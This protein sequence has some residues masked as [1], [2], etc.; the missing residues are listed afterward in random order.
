MAMKIIYFVRHGE[1]VLNAQNIRQ[2]PDGP[3]TEKGRT[4]A[5]ETAKRFPKHGGRP[6]VIIAS[7]YQRTRETAEIIAKELHMK[8]HYSELLVE[9]KNPSEII[10]HWGEEVFV[11]KIIDQ[12]D[13]SFHTDNLRISDEEN[14]VDLKARAKKLLRFIKWRSEKRIMLVTHGI[15]LKMVVSY[16]LHGDSLTA[17]EYN[18]LSSFN[19]I[20]N[21]SMAVCSYTTHWFKK[22]DW[23][24]LVWNDLS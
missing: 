15:F 4:Q 10:G 22:G 8:V 3:L 9:R 16:M 20:D 11:K 21:A 12:M 1:T 2:G 13:K 17:S 18:T 19:P 24:L 5:L 6:Q 7:P 23:K 14:F